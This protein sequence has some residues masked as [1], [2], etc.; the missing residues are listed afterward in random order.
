M[1]PRLHYGKYKLLCYYRKNWCRTLGY[2]ARVF[3]GFI[4]D[5]KIYPMPVTAAQ[6]QAIIMRAGQVSEPRHKSAI[7]LP[8]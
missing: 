3:N 6:I 1:R 8:G 2:N 7:N 5:V 4:D